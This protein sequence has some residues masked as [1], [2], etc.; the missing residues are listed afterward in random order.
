V[1]RSASILFLID[2]SK[3]AI[4][5]ESE[6]SENWTLCSF[7]Y[8]VIELHKMLRTAAAV[9]FRC[10]QPRTSDKNYDGRPVITKRQKALRFPQELLPNTALK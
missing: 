2:K 4:N 1:K 5:L 10:D 8:L 9:T 7:V 3:H 6:N